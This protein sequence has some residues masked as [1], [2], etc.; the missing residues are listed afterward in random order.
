MKQGKGKIIRPDGTIYEGQ[1][2]ANII[3]GSG[4]AT[5]AVGDPTKRDGLPK[6][7]TLRV[8]SY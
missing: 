4:K 3:I 1:W 7:V 6:K 5:I 8:F 2:D